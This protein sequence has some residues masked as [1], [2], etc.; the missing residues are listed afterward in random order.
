MT[1]EKGKGVYRGKERVKL[2]RKYAFW[3]EYALSFSHQKGISLK[4]F[5]RRIGDVMTHSYPSFY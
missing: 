5:K 3:Q 1:R 2:R 4:E